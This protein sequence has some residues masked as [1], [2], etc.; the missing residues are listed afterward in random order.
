MAEGIER[1]G[2]IAVH[3]IYFDTGKATIKPESAPALEEIAKLLKANTSLQL[4]LVGHT[5]NVGTLELNMK[6]SADRAAAV[7]AALKG[8]FNIEPS[9]RRAHGV[10]PLAPVASNRA[11]EG[12]AKNRRVDLVEP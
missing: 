3:A 2:H 7:A 11:E 4:I 5:N 10:G 8:T 12:R 9:R 6:L 1:H